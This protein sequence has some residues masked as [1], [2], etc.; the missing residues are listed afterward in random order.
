M[1][2]YT[3]YMALSASIMRV[4]IRNAMPLDFEYTILLSKENIQVSSIKQSV[5]LIVSWSLQIDFGCV[6][7]RHNRKKIHI[8]ITAFELSSKT[9]GEPNESSLENSQLIFETS[10][11][12]PE[13]SPRYFEPTEGVPKIRRHIAELSFQA[14]FRQKAPKSHEIRRNADP[15]LLDNTIPV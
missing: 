4:T 2:L 6:S 11:F 15:R 7:L 3:L 10:A 8:S 5:E 1:C 14:T 12:S 13:F 9:L